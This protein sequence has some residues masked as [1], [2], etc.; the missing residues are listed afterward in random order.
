MSEDSLCGDQSLWDGFVGTDLHNAIFERDGT[1][2]CFFFPQGLLQNKCELMRWNGSPGVFTGDKEHGADLWGGGNRDTP[3][4][5]WVTVFIPWKMS[6]R[7]PRAANSQLQP[8]EC[9]SLPKPAL[10]AEHSSWLSKAPL[11]W[12][13]CWGIQ[14]AQSG[15]YSK[16][17]SA[18]L[19]QPAIPSSHSQAASKHL[20]PSHGCDKPAGVDRNFMA[21]PECRGF[22]T[23]PGGSAFQRPSWRFPSCCAPSSPPHTAVTSLWSPL[24]TSSYTRTRQW[25]GPASFA[26]ELPL[27]SLKLEVSFFFSLRLLFFPLIFL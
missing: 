23:L 6:P 26:D 9:C 15:E 4:A 21:H 8:W 20:P 25:G 2:S 10:G 17:K 12:G 1:K 14:S 18:G 11:I 19:K 5:Q 22:V 16:E 7:K 3:A 27:V 24:V 13:W